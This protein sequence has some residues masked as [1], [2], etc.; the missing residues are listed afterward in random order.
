MKKVIVIGHK[1]PDTDSAVSAVILSK[2][3]KEEG[4]L[5][6]P[7]VAGEFNRETEF[8]FSLFN[9]EKPLKVE[10]KSGDEKFFLVDH[11]DLSQSVA[12]REDVVGVLDHHQL[13]GMKSDSVLYF[14]AEPVGSTCTLLY[15][16]I[17]D[18]GIEINKDEKGLLAS[19][20]ISDTLNLNSSTTTEKDVKY[21][22]ELSEK[23]DINRDELAE[24][25]F[26]AKSDFTGRSTEEIICGDMKEYDFNGKKVGIGVSEVTALDY[27]LKNDDTISETVKKIKQ[28]KNLDAFFFGAVDIIKQNTHFYFAGE[29]EKDLIS[30]LFSG[31]EKGNYFFLEGVSSRKKEIAPVISEYYV[32]HHSS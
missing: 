22:K 13:S 11:N 19:G 7:A 25:M 31:E 21:L 1:N 24:K 2:I 27:F 15:E 32:H 4:V 29:E 30:K 6:V 8:V 26:S 23:A 28:E 20:I 3:K 14:R 16:M 18:K 10:E 17:K 12:K 5:F 9:I